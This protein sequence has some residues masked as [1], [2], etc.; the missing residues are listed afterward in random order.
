MDRKSWP[1]YVLGAITLA[2]LV[3]VVALL[4]LKVF[5]AWTIPDLF[6]GAIDQGL[7]AARITWVTAL[8][9]AIFMA[10]LAGMTGA[11]QRKPR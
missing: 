11:H 8:K 9:V 5:W 6:P 3:F 10:V 4:L 2:G 1:G 7:V